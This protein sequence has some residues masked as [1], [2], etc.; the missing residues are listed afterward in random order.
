MQARGLLFEF[1]RM[2][3][4]PCVLEGLCSAEMEQWNSH[5]SYRNFYCNQVKPKINIHEK[6]YLHATS[7]QSHIDKESCPYQWS[8]PDRR[9]NQL[10][11]DHI[12]FFFQIFV[13]ILSFSSFLSWILFHLSIIFSNKIYFH[14]SLRK[15][16]DKIN[17]ILKI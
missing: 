3:K 14:N 1:T 9:I 10:F 12:D 11:I 6:D 7:F 2:E 8:I 4:I 17:V 5:K 13:Q 15:V 16:Q